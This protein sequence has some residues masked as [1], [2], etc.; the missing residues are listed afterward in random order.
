MD[1]FAK[2]SIAEDADPNLFVCDLNHGKIDTTFK[3]L[4]LTPIAEGVRKSLIE[5]R[6]MA[7]KGSLEFSSPA[8]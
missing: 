6:D 1:E 7:E 5:F 2:F 8:S 3:D 4:P